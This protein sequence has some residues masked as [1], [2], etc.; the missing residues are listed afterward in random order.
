[1]NRLTYLFVLLFCA[2]F[3]CNN[4]S[5]ENQVNF[6]SL[7]ANKPT[8]DKGNSKKYSIKSGVI[9]YNSSIMGMDGESKM[10]FDNYG[11]LEL[12]ENTTNVLGVKTEVFTLKSGGYIYTLNISGKTGTKIKLHEASTANMN[13]LDFTNIEA[14][15]NEGVE[16][17]N[18]GK[19]KFLDKDCDVYV[20]DKKELKGK[21]LVW[22][23][24][25]L[26]MEIEQQG[27]GGEMVATKLEENVEIPKS[28]FEVPAGF[29]IT[30]K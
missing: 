21:Y 27:F 5:K 22:G 1:M 20:I 26:K 15:K 11:E 13:N 18:T 25:L 23:N 2:L 29:S 24:I 3:S 12:T 9:T 17:K 10:Y 6:D 30:E 14:L 8:N 7:N 19:Q 28:K 16:I 4:G